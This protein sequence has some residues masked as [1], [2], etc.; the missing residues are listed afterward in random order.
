ML[1]RQSLRLRQRP[2][3][4]TE[5]QGFLQENYNI[6]ESLAVEI[7][8]R[9]LDNLCVSESSKIVITVFVAHFYQVNFVTFCLLSD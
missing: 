5:H 1:V 9:R 8:I 3:N 4:H 7:H 6:T 2:L